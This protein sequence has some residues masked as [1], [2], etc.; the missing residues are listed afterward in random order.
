EKGRRYL[1]DLKSVKM[2]LVYRALNALQAVP[3]M[4]NTKVLEVAQKLSDGGVG[5][6]PDEKR[7]ATL[8]QMIQYTKTKAVYKKPDSKEAKK[9]WREHYQLRREYAKLVGRKIQVDTIKRDLHQ[10]S[11]W[12]KRSHTF[13]L[14]EDRKPA[15]LREL[16][17]QARHMS[18]S[19]VTPHTPTAS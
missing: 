9:L 17:L 10:V 5:C 15:S 3:F 16:L 12:R 18:S 6:V 1:A 2:P 11:R 8:K 13:H 19:F 7:I 14:R 4:I